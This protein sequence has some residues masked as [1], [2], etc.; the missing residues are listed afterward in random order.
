MTVSHGLMK[1]RDLVDARAMGLPQGIGHSMR[2]CIAGQA[3]RE[4]FV[5]R[6]VAQGVLLA[7]GSHTCDE[8]EKVLANHLLDAR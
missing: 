8:K 3:R 2:S 6:A 5:G 4:G 1:D 7:S